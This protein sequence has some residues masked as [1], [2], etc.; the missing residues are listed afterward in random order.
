MED[1]ILQVIREA[2]K[3]DVFGE[4]GVL[5]YRPQLFTVRTKRLCQ[6]LRL[7]RTSFLNIVQS[8]V[9]DGTIIMN[10]LL[11]VLEP[12]HNFMNFQSNLCWFFMLYSTYKRE[13]LMDMVIYFQA[14]LLKELSLLSLK[15]HIIFII[16]G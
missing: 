10:N 6:L 7:N 12:C 15:I 1:Y 5:C 9:G 2:K 4:I 11:Q 16:S 8:N 13:H 3:G 14:Y